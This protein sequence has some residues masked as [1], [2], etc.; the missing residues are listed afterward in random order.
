MWFCGVSRRYRV[1][2]AASALM[3]VTAGMATPAPAAGPSAGADSGVE[4]VQQAVD[5]AVA[6]ASALG[7]RESVAVVDRESGATVAD[8]SGE[9][10]YISESIVK[11][12]TVAYYEVQAGG[13]PDTTLAQELRTMIIESDDSI[14]SE[15]WKTDIVPTIAARYGLANTA[16]GPRTGPDDWG[17]E[18]ITADDE[19]EFLFKMSNDPQVAPLLLDAMADVDPVGSDGF[20][21]HFGMNTLTGD[22][23]SKQGWT[24]VGSEQQIQ[25]HSVGWTDR[26]FVAILETSTTSD[27][28]T[29]RAES[30]DTAQAILAAEGTGQWQTVW[31]DVRREIGVCVHSLAQLIGAR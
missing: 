27:D 26:Y 1:L 25:I 4:A 6:S 28:D 29:M 11:L 23:G 30:T 18:L 5:D 13:H 16:N 24:D 8:S 12:F 17:W 14:E 19:A 9:T 15:L 20:D 22:H 3:I 7:I 2:A 10:Q 31:D 21:Q